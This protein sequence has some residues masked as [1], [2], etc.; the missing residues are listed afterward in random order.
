[1]YTISEK[2]MDY[3][4]NKYHDPKT[5]DI[6]GSR[7]L[8]RDSLFSEDTGMEAEAL[9]AEMLKKDEKNKALPH[10]VR[11]AICLKFLL[12]NTRIACDRRDRFPNVN[13]LDRGMTRITS[14]WRNE[15]F[16]TIIPEVEK[17]RAQLE[18]DGI[19]TIGPDY[20]H[21]VPVWEKLYALGFSGIAENAEKKKAEKAEKRP[22]TPEEEGFFDGIILTYRAIAAFTE[23]LSKLALATPGSERMGTALAKIAKEPPK[24]LYEALLLNYLYFII[25]EHIDS[26]QVR[27]LGHM[28]RLF[29]PFYEKDRAAGVPE[30]EI[31]LDLSYY[32]L[33]FASINNYWNQPMFLG[34]TRENGESYVNDF[35][36]LLIDVY[37]KLDILCPKIQIKLSENTPKAFVLR[38]LDMIRRGHSSIVF[39]PER[40]LYSAYRRLGYSSEEIRLCNITGCYENSTLGSMCI[41]MNYVNLMKPFEYALHGGCDGVTGVFGGR[42]APDSYA[43]FDDFYTEYKAQL[44]YV[45]DTVVEVVNGFE[46]YLGLINPANMLCGT[47]DTCL[48]KAKDAISGGSARNG[49]TMLFGFLANIADSLTNVKKYVFD[50]KELTLEELREMLDKNYVGYETWQKKL[51]SDPDKYGNDR[52]MPDSFASDIVKY[53]AEATC[54]KKTCKQRDGMWNCGFHVARMSYVQGKTTAASPDGRRLGEE[55]SKNISPSMGQ[56]KNGVTSLI[57]SAL[58]IDASLFTCDA[59]VDAAFHPTA[60][61]GDEGLEAFYSLL[62]TFEKGG[63]Q[64][65]HFNV[66]DA[67]TLKKAQREPEKY[68]DLQI[69]VCGW[70]N[71]FGDIAKPEQD[72]F[73]AQ[74]EALV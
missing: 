46:G 3:I 67:E 18:R 45:I 64:A 22:L 15:V 52:E 73:I 62:C 43:T 57:A 21:S 68:G 13:I 6:H 72:K 29:A 16:G 30:E 39:L 27:S 47:F 1:M 61:G 31:R 24:T 56:G 11:K 35:S 26:W 49:S 33:Q 51:F 37:D 5:Y 41:G 23:R 74:A 71:R 12:E 14:K 19:A 20:D 28:D 54:K 40:R 60:V 38:L 9:Y 55:L 25:S 53:A 48:E 2:D 42:K 50:R 65:I 59:C 70:N 63:G 66:F 34:G 10:P 17:K 58:K 7:F 36:Y 44:S 8:R 69:R 32:L 4:R